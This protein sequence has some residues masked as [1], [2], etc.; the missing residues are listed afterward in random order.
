MDPRRNQHQLYTLFFDSLVIL[1]LFV[2]FVNTFFKKNFIFKIGALTGALYKVKPRVKH[3]KPI[4]GNLYILAYG[5][6]EILIFKNTVGI[7]INL[8]EL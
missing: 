1:S 8:Y 3:G 2:A 6:F 7:E 5:F 4:I